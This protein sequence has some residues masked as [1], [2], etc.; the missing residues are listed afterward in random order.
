MDGIT[1]TPARLKPLHPTGVKPVAE[2]ADK[3]QALLVKAAEDFE[4][5]LA[6]QMVRQMQ[7]SLEGGSLFG[8]GLSG[9][10]YSGL[11]EWELARILTRDTDFGIKE[12]ILRQA[13][14]REGPIH[15]IGSR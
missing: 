15:E 3:E 9:D 13:R 2:S 14:N 6:L 10:V 11:A 5:L 7:K 1:P 4:Q 12:E 8:E